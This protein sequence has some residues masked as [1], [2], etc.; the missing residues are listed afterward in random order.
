MS[1]CCKLHPDIKAGA[2]GT[3]HSHG[4]QEEDVDSEET[5]RHKLM[6]S[7]GV[8]SLLHL[9]RFKSPSL[10]DFYL[11]INITQFNLLAVFTQN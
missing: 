8:P 11:V 10:I 6:K 3:A 4:L 1:G 7:A 2:S 9:T 5:G